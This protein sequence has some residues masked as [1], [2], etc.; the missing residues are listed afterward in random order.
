MAWIMDTVSVNRGHSTPGVV[1]GKPLSLGGSLGRAG[2]TSRGIV[3]IALEAMRSRGISPEH[4]SAAVQGFGKVG[5]GTAAF[6]AELG[7][8]VVAVSDE[9]GAIYN[10]GGLDVTALARHAKESGSVAGFA[11][12]E[13]IPGESIL[14]L[15]ADLLVPAAV[16]GVLNGRNA[17]RVRAK[18]IVEGA[19]GPTTPE[20][21]SVLADNDVLIV[22]DI[23]AN[24][25]GVVVSYFEWVQANQAYWWSEAEVEA[26]LKHR[27]MAAW[28]AVEEC[29]RH[30]SISLRR[31]ATVLAVDTVAQ[32]HLQRGLYP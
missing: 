16:E 21:D 31:A 4:A 27:M 10:A 7:I 25:G 5:A 22:P 18:V 28:S 26:R 32:A 11:M 19:N 24:A 13:S 6:L 20:A 23:L 3:H 8:R 1:T 12:A 17:G 15:E 30:R 9:Y 29:A 14:E 2:A